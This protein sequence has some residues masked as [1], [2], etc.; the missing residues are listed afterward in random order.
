[1]LT[2]PNDE[3][4]N[5]TGAY[6]TVPEFIEVQGR[7]TAYR[8]KGIGEVVLYLHGG[9]N[10]RTWLPFHE[11]LSQNH[12]LIAPE[13]PGF[14]DSERG[15]LDSFSDFAI[16]Y[17]ELLDLLG[18]DKVHLVGHSLGGWL[19][20][21]FASFYPNRLS[22]LTLFTPTG[23]RLLDVRS[24][25]TRRLAPDKMVE[26]LFNGRGDRYLDQLKVFDDPVD[27]GVAQYEEAITFNLLSWNPRY[28]LKLEARLNRLNVPVLVI[29]AD[30]D[31]IVPNEM[32]ERFAEVIPGASFKRITDKNEP[33]GHLLAVER[34]DELVAAISAHITAAGK[35]DK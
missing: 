21:E 35:E 20:S 12:D 17:D 22:S 6:W 2:H 1:M 7:R 11:K 18:V 25:D 8:R 23:L 24:I 28:S 26:A 32:A 30:D 29:G 31:R 34:P 15:E 13:H 27:E 33:T 10:T 3:F 16:H 5:R 14:G 19:A 9:G 4:A